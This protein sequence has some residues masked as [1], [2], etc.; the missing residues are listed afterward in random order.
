MKKNRKN[1]VRAA[2]AA[3]TG[4]SRRRFL[5]SV[6]AGVGA[7]SLLQS[8]FGIASSVPETPTPPTPQNVRIVTGK[9]VLTASDFQYAGL[10]T[11]PAPT[12]GVRFG[13]PRAP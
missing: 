10:F 8:Q 2:S 6:V 3:R 7:S 1:S 12:A 4:V 11:L 9:P 13:Y 5:G